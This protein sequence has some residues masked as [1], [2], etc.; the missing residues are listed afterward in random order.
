[1][2]FPCKCR[3]LFKL[4]N[5]HYFFGF[6]Q[7]SDSQ[8]TWRQLR[9]A[10]LRMRNNAGLNRISN[11]GMS[12]SKSVRLNMISSAGLKKTRTHPQGAQIWEQKYST[13]Y[14]TVCE[15][16][17]KGGKKGK[18]GKRPLPTPGRQLGI[19]EIPLDMETRIVSLNIKL[20]VSSFTTP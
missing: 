2:D 4:S 5:N 12:L 18:R 3:L 17:E 16:E 11:V 1:M 6:L 13:V 19:K 20:F 7:H 10:G 8:S 9:S 14:R 15:D